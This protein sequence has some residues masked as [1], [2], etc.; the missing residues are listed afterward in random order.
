[1]YPNMRLRDFAVNRAGDTCD[2]SG[3]Y[4]EVELTA[5]RCIDRRHFENGETFPAVRATGNRWIYD[6][7][8]E[9]QYKVPVVV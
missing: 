9:L 2:K 6:F 7:L 1:M 3:F 8:T 4:F 5:R